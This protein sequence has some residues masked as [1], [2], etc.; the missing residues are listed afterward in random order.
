MSTLGE[1]GEQECMAVKREKRRAL[2]IVCFL[3]GCAL[4]PLDCPGSTGAVEHCGD[5]HRVME[6]GLGIEG[7]DFNGGGERESLL[8]A[9]SDGK[10][11]TQ[12]ST[13]LHLPML[14][15]ERGVFGGVAGRGGICHSCLTS[16]LE[17]PACTNILMANVGGSKR[18]FF[19]K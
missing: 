5:A 6:R 12:C 9:D 7:A 1:K 15:G 13:V 11:W 14:A 8:P 17:S 16:K 2:F 10:Q 18:L 19:L 3:A 4:L